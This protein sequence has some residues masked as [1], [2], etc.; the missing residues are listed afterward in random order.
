MIY[1]TTPVPEAL[2]AAYAAGG[3]HPIVMGPFELSALEKLGVQPIGVPLL[4]EHPAGKVRHHPDR[5]AAI[6]RALVQ[7]KLG[8]WRRRA[9]S[10]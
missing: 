2:A 9:E 7:G 10:F 3:A 6:V 8:V 5:L 4:S 1:N